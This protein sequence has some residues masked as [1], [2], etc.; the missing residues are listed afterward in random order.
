VLTQST[1]C[2]KFWKIDARVY[3]ELKRT[4]EPAVDLHEVRLPRNCVAFVFDHCYSAPGE[5]IE[6]GARPFEEINIE[7]YTFPVNANAT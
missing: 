4:P 2:Q 3:R 5:A 6:Q 7:G 1:L